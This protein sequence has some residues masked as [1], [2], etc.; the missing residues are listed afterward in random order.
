MSRVTLTD[1]N[2]SYPVLQDH[3]MSIRRAMLRYM[4]GGRLYSSDANTQVVHAVKNVSIDIHEGDRIAL[5]GRNG[6]GKT[7]LL[8]TI[9]GFILPEE[10]T[11]HIEGKI[12]TL[13]SVN[14]GMDIERTGYE[15]IFLMGRL[16]DIPKVEMAK[17]IPDIEDFSE[18]GQFLSMPVRSYSDG[19]KVRL[20]FAISTCLHPD[21]LVMDEAIGAGDAHFIE[22]ATRRAQNLYERANI[23]IMAS[24]DLSTVQRMCNKA[25]WLDH[26]AVVMCGDVKD[27]VKAYTAST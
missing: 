25:C 9:A 8:K 20:G 21:I 7:T 23:I 3:Y 24:H 15:N 17:K 18:L 16:L 22:K 14:G 19:M 2:V 27:V 4:S 10:G 5:I 11:V 6:A 26:G 12:S 1:L 13:F